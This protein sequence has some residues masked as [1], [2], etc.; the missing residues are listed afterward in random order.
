M[1]F[2][3]EY[4]CTRSVVWAIGPPAGNV[5]GQACHPVAIGVAHKVFDIG[6]VDDVRFS[7]KPYIQS[8]GKAKIETAKGQADIRKP[9]IAEIGPSEEGDQV[10][11]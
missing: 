6:S 2:M 3:A 7:G 11:W 10:S 4:P 5:E 1:R 9:D 8:A